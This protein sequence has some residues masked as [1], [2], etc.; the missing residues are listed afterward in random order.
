MRA[1]QIVKKHPE[2]RD[3]FVLSAII[4]SIIFML[5]VSS[6]SMTC[7][8][9]EPTDCVTAYDPGPADCSTGLEEEDNAVDYDKIPLILVH[10]IH[11]NEFSG[12]DDTVCITNNY[13]C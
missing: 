3:Y 4:L 13:F 2:I 12:F 11:G 7:V 5:P 9:G 1:C 10:G 6:F 8:G